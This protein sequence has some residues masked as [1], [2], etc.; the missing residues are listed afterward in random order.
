VRELMANLGFR[1]MDEMVGRVDRLDARAAVRH[2]K[3]K[4]L[5]LSPI[6]VEPAGPG[7]EARRCTVRQDHGLERA[8][9]N[10]LIAAA[11]PALEDGRPVELR[12]PIRN[13]NRTV[14]TMLGAEVSRRYGGAGLPED[15]IRVHFDGSAGQSFG[16]FVPRGLTLTLEGDANDYFGKGLSGGKIIVYPP[17]QATFNS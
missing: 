12:L 15:T 11:A 4:G 7:A 2:W 6:L 14:G 9:D 10:T 1:T 3:A 16:A 8:L 5:D 17:R 13:V